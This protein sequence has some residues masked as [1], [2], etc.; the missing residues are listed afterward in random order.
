MCS[1]Q[2]SHDVHSKELH[3]L[4]IDRSTHVQYSSVCAFGKEGKEE[5]EREGDKERGREE[6]MEE[7]EG[8]CH[9][10]FPFVVSCSLDIVACQVHDASST[11]ILRATGIQ[12]AG[13][14][15]KQ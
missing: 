4:T 3:T 8:V 5:R 15:G 14:Q 11:N 1:V 2:V 12:T 10:L 7:R 6:G 13:K 9:S